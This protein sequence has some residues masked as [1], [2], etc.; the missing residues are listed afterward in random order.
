MAKVTPWSVKGIDD[1]ARRIAREAAQASGLTIGKWIDR[2]ILQSTGP[3]AQ[4]RR[5]V[6]QTWRRTV[7]IRPAATI[8]LGFGATGLA[9]LFLVVIALRFGDLPVPVGK[10]SNANAAQ[11]TQNT[12]GTLGE[13]LSLKTMPPTTLPVKTM[14]P[15]TLPLKTMPA[16][17]MP[18]LPPAP[19]P[20]PVAVA[21]AKNA[22]APVAKKEPKPKP[23][24]QLAAATT[25]TPTT[26]TAA[27]PAIS[28]PPPA[29]EPRVA[30]TT[31][32]PG[33]RAARQPSRLLGRAGI[34]EIQRLL[35]V[36]NFTPGK[37]S[38]VAGANTVGAIRLY[39]QFA[40]IPVD[41]AATEALLQDLREVT[42]NV[43][44]HADATAVR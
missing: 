18:A 39:Q 25:E 37:S 34:A 13:T 11:G 10:A 16:T 6:A 2:A 3:A 29:I 8:G 42:K 22:P 44:A 36:L 28:P 26:A 43:T 40:G 33:P 38:G 23:P 21:V 24:P 9:A 15:T 30:A 35:M 19:A 31:P 17:A 14:P 20:A 7:F 5:V 4:M 32:L 1:D 41:G 12:L 27:A